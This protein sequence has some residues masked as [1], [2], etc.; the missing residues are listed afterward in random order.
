MNGK[1]HRVKGNGIDG[2]SEKPL[3]ENDAY[4]A[5]LAKR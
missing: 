4:A 3:H 2:I 1:K 5:Y